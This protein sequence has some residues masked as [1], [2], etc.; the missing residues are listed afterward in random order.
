[1]TVEP[2]PSVLASWVRTIVDAL[3]AQGIEPAPV[4]QSVGLDSN[5]LTDPNARISVVAMARLWRK[6]TERVGDPAF[7]LRASKFIRH[8]TF[9]ALGTSV[10]ASSTM[11][12][13]VE[14][15]VRFNRVVSDV[16]TLELERD[17]Q[18]ARLLVVLKP[19]YESGGHE[20]MDAILS[21]ITRA[22]RLLAGPNFTLSSVEMRRPEP[23]DRSAYDNMFRCPIQFESGLDALAFASD[24]LEQPLPSGNPE[25]ARF[26][27]AAVREY[28]ARVQNGSLV[29]R[30]RATIAEHMGTQLSPEF[31]AKKLAMSV[32]S[33]QRALQELNSSYE[34]LLRDVREELACAYLKEK[35]YSVT[36]V[37][38]LLGYESMGAFARAF[39]RWTGMSPSDYANK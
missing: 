10:L 4:L 30:V 14:R 39:R 38:F 31:V 13:A 2:E 29:D 18:Q 36:E 27:D 22:L 6:A 21:L 3:K 5:A 34:T 20:A 28:L 33:M 11:Q 35:R 7:G 12:E 8:T 16:A 24:L 17:A 9:H 15:V 1:M 37:A 32:R 23:G 26:G 19:G 25:L